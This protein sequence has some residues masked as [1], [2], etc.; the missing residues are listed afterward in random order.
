MIGKRIG[1]IL[2]LFAMCIG[3]VYSQSCPICVIDLVCDSVPAQPKLCP[4]VLPTDTA[5]QYYETDVTFYMPQ[6][7]DITVPIS[8]T[9]TLNQIDV[10][11][12]SGMPAGLSW[13]AYDYNGANTTSFYPTANPPSSERGCA[14]ICGTPLLPGNY[15]VVVSALAYVTASGQNVTE[16]VSFNIPL[17]ILPSPNGNS[18]FTMTNSQGCDSITT[19]FSPILQSNGDPLYT[20]TWD[21]GDG[22]TSTEEFPSHHYDTAGDYNVTCQIEILEYVLTDVNVNTTNEDWCGDIEEPNIVVCIGNPDVYFRVTDVSS[23]TN[24]STITESTS[25]SWSNLGRVI[26]GNQFTIQFYDYDEIS[27]DDD[28]GSS[29]IN[30]T[31]GNHS[32]STIGPSSGTQAINGSLDIS[33]QVQISYTDSDS[34]HVYGAPVLDSLLVSPTDSVCDGDTITLS[35]SGGVTYQ[36]YDSSGVLLGETDTVYYPTESG[37]YYVEVSSSYGCTSSSNAASVGVMPIPPHPTL[38][39]LGAYLKTFTQGYPIQWYMD[40]NPIAGALSDTLNI[41]QAGNYHLTLTSD[42]GCVS[43]SDTIYMVP[44]GL[45]YAAFVRD[46]VE[47]Y[48]NPNKGVFKLAYTLVEPARVIIHVADLVGRQMF[49]TEIVSEHGDIKLPLSINGLNS[50]IYFL[51]FKVDNIDIVKKFVVQ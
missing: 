42:F 9:V 25:P 34:V 29:I 13:S 22:T 43:Y 45:E 23:L 51:N 41:H 8:A 47:L 48:P 38:V 17:T 33:T 15:T 5:Q 31:I 10:V 32:V 26:D 14:K 49:E 4:A 21:F 44:V 18:V 24:S 50:G 12:I 1:V 6:T 16:P 40:G 11:G 46:R 19:S 37:S 27:Q 39:N 36:W 3:N 30:A 7:F 35:A 28:L 2:L 20:Y